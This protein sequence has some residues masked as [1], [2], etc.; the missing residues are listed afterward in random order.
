M[1]NVGLSTIANSVAGYPDETRKLIFDTIE[2]A[3]KLKCDDLNAFNFAPY[4]EPRL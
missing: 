4:P 2:L 1:F 3:R